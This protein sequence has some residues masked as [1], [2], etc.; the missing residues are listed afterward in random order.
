MVT[1]YVNEEEAKKEK[2]LKGFHQCL[3]TLDNFQ[4]KK[5]LGEIAKDVLLY[6]AYYGYNQIPERWRKTIGREKSI[7][8]RAEKLHAL[9][10]CPILATRFEEDIEKGIEELK[11]DV[12]ERNDKFK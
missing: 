8:E 10:E 3:N 1:P 9:E 5:T 12:K 2:I 7:R 11:S 4:V 6:G